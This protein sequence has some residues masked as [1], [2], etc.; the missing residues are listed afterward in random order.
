MPLTALS[1]EGVNDSRLELAST[2]LHAMT[3]L[4]GF[5]YLAAMPLT[6]LSTEGV[7]D[8]RLE[9][10][11]TSV[12]AMSE[13]SGFRYLAAMPLT[14]LSTEGVNDSRLELAS[15]SVHAMTEL[16]GF[17]YLAA[18][19]LLKGTSNYFIESNYTTKILQSNISCQ[20]HVH[21]FKNLVVHTDVCNSSN[22]QRSVC[23]QVLK[24]FCIQN[25]PSIKIYYAGFLRKASIDFSWQNCFNRVE[26]ATH[27]TYRIQG[28]VTAV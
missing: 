12:H 9:L 3:E 14:A 27:H 21:E 16:S 17:R 2:T 25:G 24:F 23:L 11:S 8:S 6:A 18:I 13:L 1:T 19:P 26:A 10:A 15:T 28:E 22:T 4:S 20:L 7:N 5:R